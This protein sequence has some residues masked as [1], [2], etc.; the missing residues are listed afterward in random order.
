[1]VRSGD[2]ELEGWT[3]NVSRGGLRIIVEGSVELGRIYSWAVGDGPAREGRVVWV[4]D[5]PDGQI[6]GVE[7]ADG[8]E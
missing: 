1:L 5:E 3:L 8:D 4:Q 7:F 6:C 2:E